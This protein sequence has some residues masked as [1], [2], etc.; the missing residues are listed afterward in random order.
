LITISESVQQYFP[1]QIKPSQ[2]WVNFNAQADSLTIY[3]TGNPVP[4]VWEDVDEYAY[5]GFSLDD[6]SVIT[7]VKLEHFSRWLVAP[8][9]LQQHL[10]DA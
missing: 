10:Q 1:R 6:E 8:G 7:G 2:L 3:F 4:S 9:R 5:I